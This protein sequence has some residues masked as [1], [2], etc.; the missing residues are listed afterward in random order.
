MIVSG[1][2]FCFFVFLC[3]S[4][5]GRVM[6]DFM[7]LHIYS[8]LELYNVFGKSVIYKIKALYGGA[9]IYESGES[10]YCGIFFKIT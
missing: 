9:A 4:K 8:N 3:V 7:I 2:F 6:F 5:F 1:L 10:L